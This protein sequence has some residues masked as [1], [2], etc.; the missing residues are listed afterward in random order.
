[1]LK[2][3][4]KIIQDVAAASDPRDALRTMVSAIKDATH[5]EAC[6]VFLTDQSGHMFVLVSTDGLNEAAIGQVRIP[7]GQGLIGLVANK[8]EPVN[9]RD[10][11]NHPDSL[12][13]PGIGEENLK[14]FLGVPIIHY[15]SVIGVLVIQQS[16][17]RCFDE[18]EEAFLVTLSA[19]L[20]GI[21]AYIDVE[22]MFPST[23]NP[24]QPSKAKR[25]KVLRGVAGVAGVAIGQAA[26]IYPPADLEAVPER[27]AEDLDAELEV[28]ERAVI[29]TRED[30]MWLSDKLADSLPPE[31]LALFEVYVK[32][33]DSQSLMGEV[34]TEIRTGFT[35]ETALKHVIKSHLKQ[36]ESM[37]DDYL[38]ERA[39]DIKDL[40]Q[41][42]LAHLQSQPNQR[43][44]YP[45]NTILIAGE[46][47]PAA[48]AEVPEGSLL[49]VVSGAGSA[50]SHAAIVARA[51]GVPTVLG[52]D[53]LDKTELDGKQIIVDGYYGQIYICPS[54]QIIKE[55]EALIAE[56]QELNEDLKKLR[57][58][59]AT[60]PDGHRIALHVNIGLAQDA[61]A[62]FTVGAEGV[63]LFRTEL[64]FMTR[65]RF[66]S[67][68][69]QCVLYK[70]LLKAFSPRP[71]VM[72][73]LDIGGDKPLPYFPVDEINPFLGWRGIRVTLD[74][75]DLFLIQLRA[76][77][78]ASLDL[79]NLKILLPMVSGVGECE[80]A[81][82]LIDQAY[83]EVKE[84]YPT[85]SQPKIGLMIEVP[86]AVYQIE[87]LAKRVDFVSVG[88]ND[89]TQYLL[90]VDR[91]NSRVA[92]L[93]DTLHPAVLHALMRVVE[94]AKKEHVHTSVC[95][96]MAGHPL[97]AILLLAMGYDALSMNA[98]SIP[99]IKWVVQ[100]IRQAEA[101][102]L[103]RR[104][105]KMDDSA[106]IYRLLEQAVEKAGLGG[107]LRAGKH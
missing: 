42:V 23:Q 14:A 106:H 99:R 27:Q 76:M 93:F 34:Q 100:N 82:A 46:I 1:M 79:D 54:E 103:L 91:N 68:S 60:T 86:S 33:L 90:A 2:T 28:F 7:I 71:V 69:E 73:T 20:A 36:F 29:A 43:K 19:Q 102:D 10:A 105:L 67:E 51:M 15:R 22:S 63:G 89:L 24:F 40:G 16:A 32:M 74:H 37:D 77:M 45:D 31:E 50:N 53:G 21:L 72:R 4:R 75:P 13:I 6:S 30:L 48:L 88:S 25:E 38:R 56:E 41:R 35:A 84:E 52:V 107:L 64:S 26:V 104:A 83:D 66:P 101:E 12:H 62:A 80:E 95:G 94:G 58:L 87:E 98:A 61:G 65:D 55:Y 8:G 81:I 11:L 44:E 5:T 92:G 49:G 39:L 47:T 17:D 97:G 9:L 85:L 57:E 3:L 78:R 59:P 70:Q 18:S 96:E